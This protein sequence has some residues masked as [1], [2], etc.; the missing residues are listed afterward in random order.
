MLIIKY[1]LSNK[2]S[3]LLKLAARYEVLS[4]ESISKYDLGLDHPKYFMH[5][6]NDPIGKGT[7]GINTK[8]TYN[9]PIGIYGYPAIENFDE[10]PKFARYRKYIFIFSV[11]GNILYMNDYT[12]NNY[13]KDKEI[14]KNTYKLDNDFINKSES[15]SKDSRPIGKLWNLTRLISKSPINWSRILRELGYDAIY[16]EGNG[17]IHSNEQNQVI[18]INPRSIVHENTF[19]LNEEF[20]LIDSP[21]INKQLDIVYKD[22]CAIQYIKNPSEEVQLAALNQNG[23]SIRY[24]KNPS[25][26]VQLAALNQNVESIRY[27]ENPSEEVQ[28][29]AVNKKRQLYFLL[30]IHQRKFN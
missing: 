27:I 18:V 24:I 28:L 3:N 29:A 26:E 8:Y 25:E 15:N 12:E 30:K 10:L 5:F 22:P 6:S 23:E 16:D 2:I 7:L 20:R 9:T 17:L 11:N 21:S 4:K 1:N 14:L 19:Y 13:N